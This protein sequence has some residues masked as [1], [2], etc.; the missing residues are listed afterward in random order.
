MGGHP[1]LHGLPGR[2][3]SPAAMLFRRLH[4]CLLRAHSGPCRD[5]GSRSGRSNSTS[6]AIA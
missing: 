6:C 5:G 4:R 2:A 1:S 3:R